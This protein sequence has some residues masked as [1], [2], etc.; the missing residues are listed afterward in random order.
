MDACWT[1]FVRAA[2]RAVRGRLRPARAA[3]GPRLPAV[4]LP[5][6]AVEPAHGPLRRLARQPRRATRS[7]SSTPCARRGRPAAALGADLGDRL[8]ARRLRR[9]RRRRVRPRCSPSTAPTSSTSPPARRRR[10]RARVTGART[11]RRSATDPQRGRDPDR[12]RSAPSRARTTS[13]ASCSPGAPTCVR[14]PA[15]TSTTPR[16][17]LHAAAEQGYAGTG[18]PGRSSTSAARS[19][20]TPADGTWASS[21]PVRRARPHRTAAALAAERADVR[22]VSA[23]ETE[24]R[25]LARDVLAP[26]AH[27][28]EPGRVNRR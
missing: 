7:R 24:V 14:S 27:A 17:T 1:Q 16:W 23:L 10:T 26:L 2:R 25:R 20:P 8:G 11:R 19:G 4:E 15:R 21:E 9:R 18:S 12:S 13:T 6:P 22:P 28:G 3:H 5:L